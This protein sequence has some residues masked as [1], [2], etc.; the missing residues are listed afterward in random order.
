MHTSR[1]LSRGLLTG[2]ALVGAAPGLAKDY[3]PT[4]WAGYLPPTVTWVG[5]L[6]GIEMLSAIL[7]GDPPDAGFGWFHPGRSRYGWAWLAAR[8]DRNSDGIITRQEFPGPA[9]FFERLDRNHDGQL[10]AADFD[11]SERSP[12]VRQ[13]H[14]A[15][16]P[17]DAS[18]PRGLPF[19]PPPA[20]RPSAGMPTRAILLRGLL[21][22]EIGSL[23]EGPALGSPAPDF[24]LPTSDGASRIALGDYR[25]KKPVVLVF[26]SFT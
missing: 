22:G 16:R 1:W 19:A 23:C 12:R 20:P 3:R 14:V 21:T 6:E 13:A 5:R 18:N 4:S 24:M 2:M 9:A 10:T 17:G 26:G 8:C 15:E 7:G 25:D 11:W